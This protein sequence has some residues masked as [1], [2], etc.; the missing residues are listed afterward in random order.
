MSSPSRNWPACGLLASGL[1]LPAAGCA[2]YT[3]RFE[4][5]NIHAGDATY[6]NVAI[7]T[8]D[9]WPPESERTYIDHLGRK[10]INAVNDYTAPKPP[11]AS[12][13]TSI[14]INN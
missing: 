5:V 14:T 9:P 11:A 12:G 1:L 7:Q 4:S 10:T 6:A 8:I 13:T 3:N 2:D